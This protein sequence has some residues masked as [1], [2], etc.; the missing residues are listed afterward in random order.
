MLLQ[1]CFCLWV[2]QEPSTQEALWPLP[3]AV[4]PTLLLLKQATV[5]SKTENSS[6]LGRT[7][8]F[9]TFIPARAANTTA[10]PGTAYAG[11]AVA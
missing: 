2:R 6:T 1:G 5:C 8:S 11:E 3:A 4:M 10:V 7:S 9:Q